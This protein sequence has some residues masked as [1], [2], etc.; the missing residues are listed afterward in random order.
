MFDKCIQAEAASARAGS[1]ERLRAAAADDDDSPSVSLLRD[2]AVVHDSS[3]LRRRVLTL[4]GGDRGAAA[5]LRMGSRCR[6]SPDT[7][8]GA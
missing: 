1:E 7:Q 3:G 6:L 2:L 8:P 5:P 4:S